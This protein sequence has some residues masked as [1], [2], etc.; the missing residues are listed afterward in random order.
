MHVTNSKASGG[1][2]TS[3]YLLYIINKLEGEETWLDLSYKQKKLMN[4]S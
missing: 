3:I 4:M 1:K 2:N